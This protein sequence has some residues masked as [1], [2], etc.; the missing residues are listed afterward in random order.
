[1]LVGLRVVFLWSSR[2]FCSTC[3]GAQLCSRL[4]AG[5]FAAVSFALHTVLVQPDVV[6][7]AVLETAFWVLASGTVAGLSLTGRVR[8]FVVLGHIVDNL[9]CVGFCVG[10]FAE[11][12]CTFDRFISQ[13]KT[14]V[15]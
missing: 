1:M 9:L 2:C 11:D 6:C 5:L 3:V 15:H 7:V 14:C 12:L 8:L 10:N 13:V 4:M